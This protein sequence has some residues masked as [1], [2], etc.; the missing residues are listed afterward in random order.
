MNNKAKI[1]IDTDGYPFGVVA[2]VLDYDS[3]VSS[4][5]IRSILFT[6]RLIL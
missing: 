5:P 4:N 3:V 2:N 1:L 6:F